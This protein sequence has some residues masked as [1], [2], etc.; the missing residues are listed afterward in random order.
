MWRRYRKQGGGYGLQEILRCRTPLR[1]KEN[2]ARGILRLLGIRAAALAGRGTRVRPVAA[3]RK[4]G[5][6]M[7]KQ[8]ESGALASLELTEKIRRWDYDKSVIKMRELGREWAGIT[9]KVTRELYLAR[10]HLKKCQHKYPD[11]PYY[12][13]YTWKI[14]C[15]EIKIP[16]DVAGYWISKFIPREV[17][18][19]GRDV[20][21]INA[22]VKEDTAASR[23][24]MQ[25]RVNEALRTGTRPHDFTKEEDAELKRQVKNAEYAELA[26]GYAVP[27]IAGVKDYFSDALR[28]SKDIAKFKL[29]DTGQMQAQLKLFRYIEAYLSTFDD[30]ET[31]ALAALNLALKTHNIADKLAGEHFQLREPAEE[32]DG[33]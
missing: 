15:D 1:E 4:D 22:P 30:S 9:A 16:C 28:R 32:E 29:K 23:A 11:A 27:D 10:E 7:N 18:G 8:N 31:R 6:G 14:Y 25:N 20:L 21:L 19:S 24:L 12:S 33:V 5:N 26:R 13:E 17:S 3:G 2:H